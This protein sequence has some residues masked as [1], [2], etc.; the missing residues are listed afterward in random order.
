VL[1]K[2]GSQ[3]CWHRQDDA[4]GKLFRKNS[5]SQVNSNIQ[6]LITNMK[7]TIICMES[8]K[9][10]PG[11]VCS[12]DT[13]HVKIKSEGLVIMRHKNEIH[14]HKSDGDIRNYQLDK[15]KRHLFEVKYVNNETYK[16]VRG[17]TI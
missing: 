7:I 10:G 5:Q 9:K 13:E 16:N 17:N 1:G 12:N 3:I 4:E 2:A 11:G 6:I 15:K 14:S 8:C